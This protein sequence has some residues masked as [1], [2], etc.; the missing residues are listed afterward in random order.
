MPNLIQA[1]SD[2][3]MAFG[4]IGQVK[5][6]DF[7]FF[8]DASQHL[9]RLLVFNYLVYEINKKITVTSYSLEKTTYFHARFSNRIQ[10]INK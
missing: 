6:S 5:S 1:L 3:L 10:Q 7:I 2:W 9:F 4:S 8:L